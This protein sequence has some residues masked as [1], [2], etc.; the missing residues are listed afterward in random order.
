MSRAIFRAGKRVGSTDH[1]KLAL[2]AALQ[3]TQQLV[4]IPGRTLPGPRHSSMDKGR[5]GTA[6]NRPAGG[7]R[8][9]RNGN[10]IY[11]FVSTIETAHHQPRMVKG[12][13]PLRAAK[14]SAPTTQCVEVPQ[15]FSTETT[16]ID[17]L[18]LHLKKSGSNQIEDHRYI[19]TF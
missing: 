10:N 11:D 5:V 7:G 18:K 1:Q 6:T 16:R 15:N 12:L 2:F 9:S 14:K 17:W 19:E 8:S 3:D 13:L 4:E